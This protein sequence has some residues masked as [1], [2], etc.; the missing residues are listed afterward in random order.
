[1]IH[2]KD[3][4]EGVRTSPVGPTKDQSDIVQPV[5]NSTQNKDT[6]VEISQP[7]D[8]KTTSEPKNS[9]QKE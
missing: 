8:P 9:T 4:S 6:P 7:E 1:M 2:S 3:E 5:D